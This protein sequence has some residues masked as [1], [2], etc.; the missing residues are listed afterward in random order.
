MAD[1]SIRTADGGLHLDAGETDFLGQILTAM[2]SQSADTAQ[3][4]QDVLEAQ[5]DEARQNFVR[6]FT[7]L[8]KALAQAPVTLPDVDR[9]MNRFA[10]MAEMYIDFL[11][12]S[13]AAREAR[14][15]KASQTQPL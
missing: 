8:D 10:G 7:S 9:I 1:D 11:A 14:E 3:Q 4:V 6:F 2:V 13:E 5:R 12:R 15:A